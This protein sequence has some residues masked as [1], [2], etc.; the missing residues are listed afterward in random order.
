MKRLILAAL[1][2]A[3]LGAGPTLAMTGPPAGMILPSLDFP[4]PPTP[5]TTRDATGTD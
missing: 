3:T 5:D 1:A 2:A 4:E